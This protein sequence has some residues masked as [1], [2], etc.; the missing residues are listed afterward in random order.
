MWRP[1][2]R[3]AQIARA[4]VESEGAA[5][6]RFL[7]VLLGPNRRKQR[8]SQEYRKWPEHPSDAICAIPETWHAFW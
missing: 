3:I 8:K 2:V 7:L 5:L 4:G 1:H 6:F